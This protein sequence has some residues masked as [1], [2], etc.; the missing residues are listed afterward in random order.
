MRLPSARIL[1]AVAIV[2]AL[3]ASVYRSSALAANVGRDFAVIC[4]AGIV[5][6]RGGDPYH[7]PTLAAVSGTPAVPFTYPPLTATVLR[8]ACDTVAPV[9]LMLAGAATLVALTARLTGV[10]AM[11]ATWAVLSGFA[12]FPWLVLTGNVM[13]L[14]EGFC[15]LAVVWGMSRGRSAAFGTALGVAAFAKVMPAVYLLAA[16]VRWPFRMAAAGVAAAAVVF[17]GLQLVTYALGGAALT[18]YWT[19]VGTG[20]DGFVEAELRF[21]S[22]NNPSMFSFLPIATKYLGLGAIAGYGAA[23]AVAMALAAGWFRVWRFAPSTEAARVWLAVLAL[24]VLVVTYPRFKPYTLCFLLPATAMV[25][26]RLRGA[27]LKVAL[28]VVGIL[29]NAALI[30]VTWL[31]TAPPMP[32]PIVFGLQYAQWMLAAAAVGLA[33]TPG[34][35]RA[36]MEDAPAPGS[37]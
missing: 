29:P 18:Q 11:P 34:V 15:G 37:L 30:A 21:G 4:D 14:L 17:A 16:F 26:A 33:L 20:W 5:L 28:I 9:W 3:T 35:A 27:H 32:A 7:L 1:G 24:G 6:D 23:L 25:F 19:A 22:E 13:A 36:L 12:V 31:G 2:L 10:G 8:P